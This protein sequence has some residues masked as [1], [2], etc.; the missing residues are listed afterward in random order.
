MFQN[1]V[2]QPATGAKL[3]QPPDQTFGAKYITD[4]SLGL[5]LRRNTQFVLGAD[6]VFNVFPDRNSDPGDL[7]AVAPTAAE[8]R[9]FAGNYSGNSNFNI[10]R[11]NGISP[12]GFN[13]R[14]VYARVNV[15][16]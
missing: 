12:F 10:F 16:F 1:T 14:F 3:R 9:G 8:P 13:G 15:R 5:Q 6:N 11:Y 2:V 4:L 7:A